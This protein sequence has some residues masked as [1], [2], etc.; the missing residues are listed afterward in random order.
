MNNLD[1]KA[2]P[3]N[4]NEKEIQWV[5]NTLASMSL[6]EKIGQLFCPIGGAPEPADMQAILDIMHPGG[7]LFRPNNV[8]PDFIARCPASA[9]LH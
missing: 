3:F 9:A 6:D 8:C 1:L 2:K 5:E 4:L 7:L